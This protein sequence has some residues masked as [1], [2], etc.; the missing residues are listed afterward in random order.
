[1]PT[2]SADTAPGWDPSSLSDDRQ[3]RVKKVPTWS[4]DTLR[5]DRTLRRRRDATPQAEEPPPVAAPTDGRTAM[6]FDVDTL[7]DDR[8]MH[9]RPHRDADE[10]L[11]RELQELKEFTV[12]R[13]NYF[14]NLAQDSI[15]E[16][17]AV[18]LDDR[19]ELRSLVAR[20]DCAELDLSQVQD[21]MGRAGPYE[22]RLLTRSP[23][24]NYTWRLPGD[25][26]DR[27]QHRR[28]DVQHLRGGVAAIQGLNQSQSEQH[29][30]LHPGQLRTG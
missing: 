20:V 21:V 18:R 7:A 1:M 4:P 15:H 8:G 28:H 22:E 24:H 17:R 9:G 3:L 29:G 2:S 23:D 14:D 27:A 5:D 11:R 16:M 26:A 30:R 6:V 12:G 25:P 19:A 13:Y 10:S